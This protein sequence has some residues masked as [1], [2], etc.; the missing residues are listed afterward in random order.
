[1]A[2][3]FEETFYVFDSLETALAIVRDDNTILYANK[4]FLKLNPSVSERERT[5]KIFEA[6][7]EELTEKIIGA[8]VMLRQNPKQTSQS[9][10]YTSL[11]GTPRCDV[12]SNIVDKYQSRIG[13][14]IKSKEILETD[15]LSDKQ[16]SEKNM[17]YAK[18]EQ[19]LK[20]AEEKQDRDFYYLEKLLEISNS[21]FSLDV[22]I[23]QFFEIMMEML[24]AESST[25]R[26]VDA[27]KKIALAPIYTYGLSEQF[28][29]KISNAPLNDCICAKAFAQKETVYS[30]DITRDKQNRCPSC[31]EE[32]L[33]AIVVLPLM[34][35]NAV[36]G[37][38]QFTSQNPRVFT[39]S[40]LLSLDI[41]GRIISKTFEAAE[42]SE[43]IYNETTRNSTMLKTL[44]EP[45]ALVDM[46]GKIEIAGDSLAKILGV[47]NEK[48]DDQPISKLFLPQFQ[49]EFSSF[50][51]NEDGHYAK[52]ENKVYSSE[53][54]LIAPEREIAVKVTVNPIIDQGGIPCSSLVQI[55]DLEVN[56]KYIRELDRRTKEFSAMSAMI[57][58]LNNEADLKD[59][60]KKALAELAKLIPVASEQFLIY[61]LDENTHLLNVIAHEGI[62][63]E[64]IEENDVVS[65][66]SPE[67]NK[68]I[69][70]GLVT[71]SNIT[72]TSIWKTLIPLIYCR[73]V[74]GVIVIF[75]NKEFRK[76]QDNEFLALSGLIL[77]TALEKQA[78]YDSFNRHAASIDSFSDKVGN[79]SQLTQELETT[80]MPNEKLVQIAKAILNI[81][82]QKRVS[83]TAESHDGLSYVNYAFSDAG[84]FTVETDMLLKAGSRDEY[85]F[86]TG[87]A[88]HFSLIDK[89]NKLY[90]DEE[91]IADISCI[92]VFPY[93]V[94]NKTLAVLRLEGDVSLI[95]DNHSVNFLPILMNLFM[96]FVNLS[97]TEDIGD[98]LNHISN[99]AQVALQDLSQAREEVA[100]LKEE[101]SKVASEKS[102]VNVPAEAH[103]IVL[104]LEH[105]NELITQVTSKVNEI[106]L[107]KDIEDIRLV[108]DTAAKDWF[109]ISVDGLDISSN[110]LFVQGV[111]KLLNDIESK[112]EPRTCAMRLIGGLAKTRGQEIMFLSEISSKLDKWS[113]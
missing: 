95:S 51:S 30:Q 85:V 3:N 58:E 83:V 108:I 24:N 84:G 61:Y 9:V 105:S 79:L 7:P 10:F 65:P 56:A 102:L 33:R 18:R 23:E 45:V 62:P 106:M 15:E 44:K 96:A 13:I 17:S 98:E 110:G 78:L 55:E 27:E 54:K 94:Q 49:A 14:V 50:F 107:C 109:E 11:K 16:L 4:E 66:N 103:N 35:N 47:S 34:Y 88:S 52:M 82:E 69:S 43:K 57:S 64:F 75:A 48:L 97:K 112:K 22:L 73:K 80:P 53:T 60:S 19:A 67:F 63:Q 25:L 12:F 21:N 99:R 113:N 92:S 100:M 71:S 104:D 86:Q 89:S 74:R 46:E 68:A 81:S 1:M 36:R 5:F 32:G 72:G 39:D 28:I 6:Y 41:A 70:E 2:V 20:E 40:E 111:D 37:L 26:L 59:Y 76:S 29:K 31:R 38:L 8:M 87:K 91:D 101:L 93:L 42:L 90:T 77:G